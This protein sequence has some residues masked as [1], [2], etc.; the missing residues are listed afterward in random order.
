MHRIAKLA[1]AVLA[2]ALITGCV[3]PLKTRPPGHAVASE[4]HFENGVKQYEMGHYK[5]AIHQ[6]EKAV[7]KDPTN[8]KAYFY[9]GMSH[10]GKGLLT[11]ARN[12]LEKALGL[13]G[14]DASWAAKI[15]NQLNI[16]TQEQEKNKHQGKGKDKDK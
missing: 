1:A 4:N 10:K 9:L 3:C 11:Q 7:Q 14:N 12:Y 5:Q 2:L 13:S 16:M 15:R 8:Y 6:F